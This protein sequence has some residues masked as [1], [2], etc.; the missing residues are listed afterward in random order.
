MM[1]KTPYITNEHIQIEN[2]TI[3][4]YEGARGVGIRIFRPLSSRDNS[5]V[6]IYFHD[7]GYILGSIDAS[8][9]YAAS[10]AASTNLPVISFNYSLAPENKYPDALYD[11]YA[12][13]T[14]V[15]EN[16]NELNIDKDRIITFGTSAGG[17]LCS[18]LNLYTRDINGPEP[19]LQVLIQPMLD[20]RNITSSSYEITD[21]RIWNRSK[22]IYA[23]NTYLGDLPEKEIPYTAVP[24]LCDDLSGLPP[25]YI[26]VGSVE[27]FRDEVIEFADKLTESH[28]PVEFN[29]Y[30]GGFHG[31]EFF[32]PQAE[33]SRKSIDD[34]MNYINNFV[35]QNH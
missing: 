14:Y 18:A 9:N 24:A 29:L 11:S 30:K 32:M 4:G 8:A 21:N 34:V 10:V 12:V 2:S 23:W 28:V 22:N 13:L 16:S 6:I 17:G 1:D 19:M 5:P 27:V 20:N 31:F 25:T 7:G 15:Y 33:I 26:T 3:P 35:E